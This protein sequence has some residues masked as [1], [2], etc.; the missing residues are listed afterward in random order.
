MCLWLI[1]EADIFF[2]ISSDVLVLKNVLIILFS[3]SFFKKD[4]L[5]TWNI[6]SNLPDWFKDWSPFSPI[7]KKEKSFLSTACIFFSQWS[8]WLGFISYATT[9]RSGYIVFKDKGTQPPEQT[10]SRGYHWMSAQHIQQADKGC[11]FDFLETTFGKSAG[12]PDIFW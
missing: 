10:V 8:I 6:S 12:E 9:L 3:V 4:F 11:D 1:H 5:K 2:I 7:F